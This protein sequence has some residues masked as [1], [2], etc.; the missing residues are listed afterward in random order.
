MKVVKSSQ[1]IL[2]DATSF[3]KEKLDDFFAEYKRVVNCFIDL[4]WEVDNLP[5][6]INT[7]HYSQIDSWLLGKA[8]K[9]AGN[10]ALQVI[11][12]TRK[13]D[14]QRTYSV[15]KRVFSKAKKKKKNWDLVNQ[16]WTTW[17]KSKHFRRRISKPVFKED[18]ITLNADLCHIQDAKK[19]NEFDLW[20]RI[21]SVF[22]NRFSLILPT[23]K[24]SHF[25]KIQKSGF[26]MKK[27]I[28]LFKNKRGNYYVVLTHEKEI[29]DT[30]KEGKVVGIDVGVN[31]LMCCDDGENYT[32]LGTKVKE[33]IQKLQTKKQGSRGYEKTCR[34][35]KHYIGYSVNQMDWDESGA[36]SME[37]LDYKSMM[38]IKNKEERYK[39]KTTRKLLGHWNIQTLT[40]R[41]Q[42]KCK[43]NRVHLDF[44]PPF[45]TSRKC[46]R[47]HHVDNESRKGELYKCVKCGY[48]IDADNNASTNMRN[49]LLNHVGSVPSPAEQKR[50]KDECL[51]LSNFT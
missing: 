33:K 12:S 6:K 38:K 47:C 32:Q 14:K 17:S 44:V 4:F 43:V 42:E 30:P 51:S 36:I 50:V 23:R 37:D 46:S 8:M 24:H 22:G 39:G 26:E 35:I 11:K 45:N 41:I 15:Y 1:H 2:N 29:D 13:K 7:T 10:Q 5:P 27:S 40:Q 9:C 48:E 25:N 34:E 19:S 18:T 21:G 28:R 49:L 16:K 31:K 3:K 20:I